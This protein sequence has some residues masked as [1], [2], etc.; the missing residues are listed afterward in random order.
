MKAYRR[1]KEDRARNPKRFWTRMLVFLLFGLFMSFAFKGQ[2]QTQIKEKPTRILFIFDASSSMHG[3]WGE[4][5]K[6]SIAKQ[7]L[8][9]S[10]DSFSVL[11]PKVEFA[12]RVYGHQSH[13]SLQN[14]QDSRLEV[15]FSRNNV[16]QIKSKL[17]SI[18]AQG[19]T[20]IEYSITQAALN[21]FPNAGAY[22]NKLI[23]ITDG[24]EKCGGN[25]CNAGAALASNGI[26]LEPKVIGMGLGIEGQAN[27]NC[28]GEYFEVRTADEMDRVLD[29]VVGV[30]IDQVAEKTTAQINLID[31][32]SLP[33]RTDIE[34]EIRETG[35]SLALLK[36]QH[37]KRLG[38]IPDTIMLDPSKRYDLEVF[39]TPPSMEKNIEV[40]AG[41]HNILA[42]NV[43]EGTLHLKVIGQF[44][45]TDIPCLVRQAGKDEIIFVQTLNSSKDYLVGRYDLEI[46]TLPR[47]YLDNVTISGGLTTTESIKRSG[48][49][50]VYVEEAGVVGVFRIV[51]D[52]WEKVYEELQVKDK[53]SVDLQPGEYRVIYRSNQKRKAERS[54]IEKLTIYPNKSSIAKF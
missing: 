19:Y 32:Q 18:K 9:S 5:T 52:R 44:G 50:N 42:V 46:L 38:G 36:M 28:V 11:Y 41:R 3:K 14:C 6:F 48:K 45:G 34:F 7:V 54:R 27:F 4:R 21:D 26:K 43:P 8:A 13:Q 20:P 39:T 2:S 51:E 53:L 37:T 17:Y 33:N 1:I 40:F 16:G 10:L 22:N 30:I 25:P 29:E 15:P 49:L 12:L 35:S 23:L 24:L 31:H 47:I